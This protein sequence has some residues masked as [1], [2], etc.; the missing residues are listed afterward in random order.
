MVTILCLPV[1][2]AVIDQIIVSFPIVPYVTFQMYWTLLKRTRNVIVSK[3]Q[4]V[5]S[6]VIK[7][8][9]AVNSVIAA[10]MI[11]NAMIRVAILASLVN[12]N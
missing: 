9:K 8:L 3:Y 2:L 1:L 5:L 11:K 7:L 10:T 4:K 12:M 6:V